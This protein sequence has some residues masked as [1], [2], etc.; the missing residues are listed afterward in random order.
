VTY[1][2]ITLVSREGNCHDDLRR[3]M[4]YALAVVI[5]L[6]LVGFAI[7]WAV[8]SGSIKR[9]STVLLVGPAGA[10]KTLM[11]LQ[12][13]DGRDAPT[14]M[15]MASNEDTFA[16]KS[17]RGGGKPPPTTPVHV[18]DCPGAPQLQPQMLSRLSG[19]G[20]I[21]FV[22]DASDPLVQSKNAAGVLYELF[23]S[24][25]MRRLRIPVLIACNKSDSVKAMRAT[26]L[27]GLIEKEIDRIQLSRSTMHD[28]TDKTQGVRITAEGVPFTFREVRHSPSARQP[29]QRSAPV[30]SS[31]APRARLVSRPVSLRVQT[32]PGAF[33][34]CRARRLLCDQAGARASRRLHLHTS[35]AVSKSSIAPCAPGGGHESRPQTPAGQQ[36]E[37]A[38]WGTGPIQY[39]PGC[40]PM[41]RW[42]PEQVV[43][44]LC[45]VGL[46]A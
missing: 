8:R 14:H 37:F 43:V 17:A 39:E 35:R 21:V 4:S 3:A 28:L 42:Q 27:R 9:G 40:V 18:I 31:D 30:S 6:A 29:T 45:Q 38:F 34:E 10:G 44:R 5:L 1:V 24:G 16:L 7:F 15:S 41:P 33:R 32:R 11:F 23:I 26:Q 12:M 20:V 13:R 22:L 2:T 19:A 46:H 36:A 25:A